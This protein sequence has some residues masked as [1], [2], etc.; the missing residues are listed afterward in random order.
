MIVTCGQGLGAGIDEFELRLEAL[1]TKKVLKFVDT[2]E[3]GPQSRNQLMVTHIL[4][5][6]TLFDRMADVFRVI[7]PKDP[8]N[9][10]RRN[11][12]LSGKLPGVVKYLSPW[13][14]T[15]DGLRKA[16]DEVEDTELNL[17][18]A[19]LPLE[20][21]EEQRSFDTSLCHLC[22]AAKQGAA[23]QMHNFLANTYSVGFMM[24]WQSLVS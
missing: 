9:V 21:S 18:K 16:M 3:L 2:S 7:N 22:T 17:F 4:Y 6:Y 24:R 20:L 15:I 1:P 14:K 12:T 8:P 13:N 23:G 11:I 5:R 19:P 10:P